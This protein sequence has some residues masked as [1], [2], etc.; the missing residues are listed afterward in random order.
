MRNELITKINDLFDENLTLKA[1]NAFLEAKEEN[2][3]K[4]CEKQGKTKLDLKII[5]YGKAALAK[6]VLS[7]WGNEVRVYRDQDSKE[8]IITSFEKWFKEKII[9]SNVPRNLCIDEVN[10]LIYAYAIEQYEKEKTESVK[11]F[12]ESEK[13]KKEKEI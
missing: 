10:K 5:E 8:I 11:K 3:I 1:R 4:C 13:E 6:E 2:E 7:T 12:E 9:V